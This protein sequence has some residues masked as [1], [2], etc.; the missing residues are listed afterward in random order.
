[1]RP[2]NCRL[3]TRLYGT[4]LVFREEFA[5]LLIRRANLEEWIALLES[6]SW[7]GDRPAGS[8]ADALHAYRS[9]LEAVDIALQKAPR[10]FRR[11][12]GSAEGDEIRAPTSRPPVPS[13]FGELSLDKF[14]R[15][16]D[17]DLG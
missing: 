9:M 10:A 3:F 16:P 5:M 4:R 6:G 8:I 1:M 13:L 15:R 11:P 7:P 17:S 14:L 12:Q 2:C